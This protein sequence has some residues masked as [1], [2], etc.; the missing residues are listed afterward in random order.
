MG[1]TAKLGDLGGLNVANETSQTTSQ[2]YTEFFSC[3]DELPHYY[4]FS[5]PCSLLPAPCSLKKC[6]SPN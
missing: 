5:V 3:L 2:R 6:A 4:L 1:R